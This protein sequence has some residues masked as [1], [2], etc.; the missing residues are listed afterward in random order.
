MMFCFVFYFK[1][2]NNWF[3]R[4]QEKG[5]ISFWAASDLLVLLHVL[6][7]LMQNNTSSVPVIVPR[8]TLAEFN[9]RPDALWFKY[10][11]PYWQTLICIQ[12][13]QSLWSDSRDVAFRG[14]KKA[15]Q[16][17]NIFR[18]VQKIYGQSPQQDQFNL[19]SASALSYLHRL[20]A[21]RLLM[22]QSQR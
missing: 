7:E 3:K 2:N 6:C 19:F 22:K 11:G 15:F 1:K 16:Q 4:I 13:S 18:H 17:I 12:A 8:S 5:L 21:C 20:R 10:L 14:G 9:R